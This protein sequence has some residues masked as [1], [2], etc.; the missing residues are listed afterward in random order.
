M[1]S[2]RFRQTIEIIYDQVFA[3][4]RAE[5]YPDLVAERYIQ[6]NPL[7][8]DGVEGVMA[9]LKQAGRVAN[10]VKRVPI[11]GDLAFVHVR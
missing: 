1:T 5:L 3:E 2:D 10:E 6:H 8:A 7:V 11:D 9:F 4:G